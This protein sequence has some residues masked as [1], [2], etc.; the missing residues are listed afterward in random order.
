MPYRPGV[1]PFWRGQSTL[2]ELP[3]SVSP[4]LRLPAIGTSLLL[5]PTAVRVRLLEAMRAR[6]FFNLELH[7]LDLID[8]DEDGIPAALVARQPDLR[9]PLVH[10]RRALEATLDRLAHE[11]RFWTLREVAT[12]VQRE[13]LA[14]HGE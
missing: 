9:V 14:V 11:Y 8:A 2:V 5:A 13:G 3:I 1:S 7:G 12:E 10:K 6:P 4:R